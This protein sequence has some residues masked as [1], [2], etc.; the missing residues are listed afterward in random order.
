M[1]LCLMTLVLFMLCAILFLVGMSIFFFSSFWSLNFNFLRSFLMLLDLLSLTCLIINWFAF[2]ELQLFPNSWTL[3][4]SFLNRTC[5]CFL[6]RTCRSYL[7]RTCRFFLNKTCRCFLA[8]RRSGGSLDGNINILYC[9]NIECSFIWNWFHHFLFTDSL[10]CDH[11][12][13]S[14]YWNNREFRVDC[15]CFETIYLCDEVFL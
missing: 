13:K 6:N 4:R 15:C 12:F 11:G 2:W 3:C 9:I 7:N 10:I 14:C 1:N 5:R 8:N